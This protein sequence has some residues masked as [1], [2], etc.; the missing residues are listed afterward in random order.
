[1]FDGAKEVFE[2]MIFMNI[3]ESP[4]QNERLSGDTYLGSITFKG[5]IEG[6]LGVT[7]TQVCAETVASNMLCLEP[8]E[9]IPEGDLADAIGEVANMVMGSVKTRVQDTIPNIEL[10]IPT[11]IFGRIINSNVGDCPIKEKIRVKVDEYDAELSLL[12]RLARSK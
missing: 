2:T 12:C 5:D 11:V 8:G 10:S 9:E 6:C 1:M 3:S 4:D 7:M